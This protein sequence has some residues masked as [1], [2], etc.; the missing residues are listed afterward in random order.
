MEMGAMTTPEKSAMSP[1]ERVMAALK[2]QPTDRVP[3]CLASREVSIRQAGLT[4]ADVWA[5]GREYVR[6]QARL[7]RWL[8]LDMAFDLWCNVGV[9]EALGA[10]VELPPDNP[11][12]VAR[13]PFL[14][15]KADMRRLRLDYDSSKDGRL[16]MI[17]DVV[18]GLRAELGP[19]V[20]ISAWISPPFR[21]ACMLRG[22]SQLYLDLLLDPGFVLELLEILGGPCAR[23]GLDL[24]D[25]GA[26][27]ICISNPTANQDCISRELYERFSH[28]STKRLFDFLK[29]E[30]PG[31]L[32][33][34][35]TCGLWDDRLDLVA[36][37]SVDVLHVDKVDLGALKRAHGQKLTIMGKVSAVD[38]LLQG[39][40]EA[41]LEEAR[42]DIREGWPGG[43]FLLSAN[44]TV[45]PAAPAENLLAMAQAA[46][47]TAG[48]GAGL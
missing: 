25:A 18:R 5:D 34:F 13:R 8:G 3:F 37:E 22:S 40:P 20:P 43:R 39:T 29:G 27:F 31:L 44:C 41:V 32:T 2:G 11:P 19:D 35:H 45:P 21:T 15:E 24:A 9:D 33:M 6:A 28:H 48:G 4:F 16:P 1:R 23:F 47:E 14:K 12:W 17:L 7:V 36:A 46:R 42:S 26:D 38:A 30:R 10:K